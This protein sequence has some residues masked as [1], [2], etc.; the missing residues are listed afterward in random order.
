MIAHGL[1]NFWFGSR[2]RHHPASRYG[3]LLRVAV[4]ARG[5]LAADVIPV[6][7][8]DNRV[9]QVE[10]HCVPGFDRLCDRLDGDEFAQDVETTRV[11]V[12]LATVL[13]D[14]TARR[15]RHDVTGL[16]E[17]QSYLCAPRHDW[18]LDTGDAHPDAAWRDATTWIREFRHAS[19]VLVERLNVPKP[20]A[21]RNLDQLTD[22]RRLRGR[23]A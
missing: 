3:M 2:G 18:L 13:R 20:P 12:E 19:R 16:L 17:R 5:A 9:L 1:G 7:T 14:L 15:E 6:H 22:T 10:Q 21:V 8:D 11:S 4:D 23:W